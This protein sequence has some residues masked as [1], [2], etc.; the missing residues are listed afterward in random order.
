MRKSLGDYHLSILKRLIA[1]ALR[2]T[3]VATL[4]AIILFTFVA[5][6][7]RDFVPSS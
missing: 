2:M 6:A 7:N 4:L 1:E 3:L 5:R